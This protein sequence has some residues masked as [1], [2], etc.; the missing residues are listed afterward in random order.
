MVSRLRLKLVNRGHQFWSQRSTRE[1]RMLSG[2]G[3]VVA[4]A[5]L[6]QGLW[7]PVHDVLARQRPE[8][9]RLKAEAVWMDLMADE[10]EHLRH[11]PPLAPLSSAELEA[12]VRE[13]ASGLQFPLDGWSMSAQGA[14][15]GMSGAADF[16]HWLRLAG[17]LESRYHLTLTQLQ[18]RMGAEPGRV[19]VQAQLVS[20]QDDNRPEL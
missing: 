7:L 10:A 14:G 8:V 20:G 13:A 12:R 18:V 17:V 3:A 9:G 4:V 19:V 1:R 2:L 15:L 5:G 16:D 11:K 6:I